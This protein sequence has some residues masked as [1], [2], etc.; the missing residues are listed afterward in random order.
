MS[1]PIF[2]EGL[3]NVL[4]SSTPKDLVTWRGRVSS[5]TVRPPPT[6]TPTPPCHLELE[7]VGQAG[8]VAGCGHRARADPEHGKG[9]WAV[10]LPGLQQ[11]LGPDAAA[12][13]PLP[14][15]LYRLLPHDW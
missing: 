10:H 6:P 7:Q 8:W 13:K 3:S 9:E 2:L 1:P 4:V 14:H 12:T 5:C 11:D 15:S